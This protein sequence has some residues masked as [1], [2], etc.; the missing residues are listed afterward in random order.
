MLVALHATQSLG[1]GQFHLRESPWRLN[2]EP[3]FA[4]KSQFSL[5]LRNSYTYDT[6]V[7]TTQIFEYPNKPL[8]ALS[9]YRNENIIYFNFL[10]RPL[11]K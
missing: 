10:P 11:T 3:E 4:L 8:Y 9:K 1:D 2:F 7:I 5:Q 6:D